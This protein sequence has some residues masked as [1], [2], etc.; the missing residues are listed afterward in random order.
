M[1]GGFGSVFCQS[2]VCILV[3]FW[4]LEAGGVSNRRVETL[5]FSLKN[6]FHHSVHSSKVQFLLLEHFVSCM[7]D[8]NRLFGLLGR[9]LRFTIRIDW[10]LTFLTKCTSVFVPHDFGEVELLLRSSRPLR[11]LNRSEILIKKLGVFRW[12]KVY[13]HVWSYLEL[14]SEVSVDYLFRHFFKYE[15]YFIS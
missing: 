7:V 14:N 5:I 8:I 12:I 1:D 3:Q 6:L 11:P 10:T 13:W 4:V 15:I 9:K 2:N